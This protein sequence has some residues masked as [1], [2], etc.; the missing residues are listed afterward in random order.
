MS[1]YVPD[2]TAQDPLVHHGR[3]FG[4]AVH[5]FCNVQTLITNGIQAMSDD[6]P[7]DRLTATCVTNSHSSDAFNITCSE[8]K[9]NAVFRE[10]LRIVPGIADRIVESSEDEVIAIA[11]LVSLVSSPFVL[12]QNLH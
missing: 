8:R 10:L 2:R 1:D 9:E 12:C 4:R 3:H 6:V 7:G 11:D 5:A